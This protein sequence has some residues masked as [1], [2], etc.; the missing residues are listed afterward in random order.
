[1][2]KSCV[3]AARWS[4]R[5]LCVRALQHFSQP[6]PRRAISC[7]HP[8]MRCLCWH[9]ACLGE[10]QC[11]DS[12]SNDTA[13][14]L[15]SSRSNRLTAPLQKAVPVPGDGRDD[16]KILRA[17]SEV[18]GAPL[19]YV[20]ID[21]VRERLA[22]MAPHMGEVRAVEAPLWLNGEYFK[23]SADVAPIDPADA[24]DNIRTSMQPIV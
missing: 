22:A 4:A 7:C 2:T 1:M 3:A 11:H 23:V 9:R 6:S 16:W 13:S 8:F 24:N 5:K 10:E 19:P 15:L 14:L 21:A 18:A 17:L 12:G 20:D